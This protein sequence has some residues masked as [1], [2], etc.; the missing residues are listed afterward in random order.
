MLG[1]RSLRWVEERFECCRTGLTRSLWYNS[2]L[3]PASTALVF[4]HLSVAARAGKR[5]YDWA[6]TSAPWSNT[7]SETTGG[8]DRGALQSKAARSN[9]VLHIGSEPSILRPLGRNRTK[10]CSE[11][12]PAVSLRD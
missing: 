11:Q 8:C 5:R 12:E 4:G 6:R 1:P 7:N 2:R 3:P 10:R 9:E